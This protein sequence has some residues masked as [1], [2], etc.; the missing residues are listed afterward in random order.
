MTARPPDTR[1]PP[2]GEMPSRF[3]AATQDL[4][5]ALS[6]PVDATPDNLRRLLTRWARELKR[7][8][9]EEIG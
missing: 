8:T 3:Q 7:A 1:D 4:A 6:R 2:P 9:P 5:Y